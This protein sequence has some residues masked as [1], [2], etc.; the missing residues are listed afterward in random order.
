MNNSDE[1][2]EPVETEPWERRTDE[3]DKAWEAFKTYRDMPNRTLAAVG[4]KLVKSGSL[5]DRW[6]AKYDWVERVRSLDEHAD[7]AWLEALFDDRV[8]T[9]RENSETATVVLEK[10]KAR[11]DEVGPDGLSY[12][13]GVTLLI[14]VAKMRREALDWAW[15]IRQEDRTDEAR[16]P[17][18]VIYGADQLV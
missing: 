4:K 14:A 1:Q 16:P 11:L 7:W 3:T 2:L 5:I 10:I 17:V 6:R 12:V 9:A 8:R 18:V 13:Q 15:A